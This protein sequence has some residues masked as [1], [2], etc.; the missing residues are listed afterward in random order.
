M[1]TRSFNITKTAMKNIPHSSLLVVA[2]SLFLASC[3]SIPK[4]VVPDGSTRVMANDPARISAIQK[5]VIQDRTAL[6]ENNALRAE[7]LVIREQLNEMRGIIRSALELPKPPALQPSPAVAPV[8]LYPARVGSSSAPAGPALSSAVLPPR[9][10]ELIDG[11]AVVRVF[12]DFG[13]TNFSPADDLAGILLDTARNSKSIRIK[14]LTDNI[15]VSA[16]NQETARL[17]ALSAWQW[18]VARGIDPAV[19]ATRFHSTGHT[20]SSNDSAEGRAL[21][22]RVEIEFRGDSLKTFVFADSPTASTL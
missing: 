12:H 19:I 1:K 21:N 8:V 10:Y 14:G 22:R 16:A 7:L 5:Q 9:S 11:G 17:R 2:C 15:G 13:K 18:M 6:T 20:L 3:G 4:P